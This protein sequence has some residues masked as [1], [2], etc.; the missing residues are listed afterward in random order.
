[1]TCTLLW[2]QR[3]GND[4]VGD[5][6]CVREPA[7]VRV[8]DEADEVVVS[9][10]VP[11]D[12][13]DGHLPARCEPQAISRNNVRGPLRRHSVAVRAASIAARTSGSSGSVTGRKRPTTRPPGE[14]RNFSKFH[15]TSPPR[16]SA[17]GAEVNSW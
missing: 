14:T 11:L 9:E 1:M 17:S 16:P 7:L 8:F 10:E 6:H 12:A 13:R 15:W 5:G 2:A 3:D 4:V